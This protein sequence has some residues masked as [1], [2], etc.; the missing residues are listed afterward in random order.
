MKSKDRSC[1]SGRSVYPTGSR[2]GGALG[3]GP[4][5][6]NPAPAPKIA[7]MPTH[8]KKAKY[9]MLWRAACTLLEKNRATAVL[10]AKKERLA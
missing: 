3:F 6:R 10:S 4:Q 8:V 7:T 1:L 9:R 5:T 2:G